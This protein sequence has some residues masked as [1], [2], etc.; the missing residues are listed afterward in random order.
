MPIRHDQSVLKQILTGPNRHSKP[1]QYIQD[2]VSILPPEVAWRCIYDALPFWKHRPSYPSALL[3]LTTV[4]RSWRDLIL[5]TSFFWAEIYVHNQTQDLLVTLSIFLSLSRE[6]KLNLVIWDHPVDE[7]DHVKAL[8][9]PHVPRIHLLAV[10]IR[11][12]GLSPSGHA[13]H[14][15]SAASVVINDLK[16][17]PY[18]QELD[19]GEQLVLNPSQF[20]GVISLSG[21]KVTSSIYSTFN[22]YELNYRCLEHFTSVGTGSHFDDIAPALGSLPNLSTLW[23]AKLDEPFQSSTGNTILS[24]AP[25][26]L[27][28]ID[29]RQPYSPNLGRF[30]KLTASLLSSLNVL[31]TVSEIGEVLSILPL[32]TRLQDLGLSFREMGKISDGSYTIP[33]I[34]RP[35]LRKLSILVAIFSGYN[36]TSFDGLFAVLSV[37]YPGVTTVTLSMSPISNLAVSYLQ[38]LQRLEALEFIRDHMSE[39]QEYCQIFL[40]T[41]QELD[42]EDPEQIHSIRAPNLLS[43]RLSGV[44]SNK[45]LEQ[46][47]SYKLQNLDIST[48][49]GEPSELNLPPSNLAELKRLYILFRHIEDRWTFSSLPFLVSIHLVCDNAMNSQGN[50]LC[51]Q[52]IYHPEMCPSLREI[53]FED[54]IE[55]DLLFIM[56]EQRNLGREDVAR[57]ER[58]SVPFVPFPFRQALFE[59]LSGGQRQAD[60]SNMVLSLEETREL[61]CDPSIPGCI[62]CLKNLRPGCSLIVE[63][64]QPHDFEESPVIPFDMEPNTSIVFPSIDEWMTQRRQLVDKWKASFKTFESQFSRD[65]DCYR[66]D[67]EYM[68]F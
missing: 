13:L 18:L 12:E 64:I 24:V 62:K 61:I 26:H 38:S 6:H 42:I 19:F 65:V 50:T 40:P 7:W 21:I 48:W 39:L 2:P 16:L 67:L 8:L 37:L 34:V 49:Y 9:I 56:L 25:P 35:S 44:T 53:E 11:T 33:R 32:L 60:P 57:I 36:S 29:G 3:Q 41:L 58:V 20:E 1:L 15:L 17:A 47:Q 27:Q 43:L 55:W 52:L 30:I 59:V 45:Q 63:S 10:L 28:R 23:L 68:A 46:L 14:Q 51:T 5:S 54:Y 22:E 66:Q 31:I 4:S